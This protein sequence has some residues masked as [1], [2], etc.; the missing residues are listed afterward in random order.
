MVSKTKLFAFV[1][2]TL[3]GCGIQ[4]ALAGNTLSTPRKAPDKVETVK[5]FN[6][7]KSQ[8][9]EGIALDTQGN[10][11]VGFYPTG[12]IWKITPNGDE[13]VFATLD[14]GSSGGGMVGFEL[15]QEDNL[16]VCDATFETATHGIWKV[17]QNGM[18]TLFAKLDP[19]GFPNDLVFDKAGNL[20]VTDSYLGEIWKVS[21]S[22]EVEAWLLDRLLDPLFAYG[23][24][25]IE[26]DRG[27]L[28][29]ANTD[30]GSIVRIRMGRKG[31]PP[32]AELFVQSPVLVGADGISFDRHHNLYAT[33]DY[34][35]LLV[36]IDSQG[37]IQSMQT[38]Q[39]LAAAG[40]GLDF[41]ADTAFG[42][43]HGQRTFLFWTNGGYNFNK[44]SVQ[45]VNV[46]DPG[47][48][49]P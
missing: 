19:T 25:G 28:F 42:Q 34:Q 15:D 32:H 23:A 47:E 4:D 35:N 46:G 11:Y 9:P 37:Q 16:Y 29:V 1:L 45:K 13:S 18:P 10:I 31:G 39:T 26:F 49:L 38:I 36:A 14:V 17:D 8:L 48:P 33:V 30:Q 20:F 43:S 40:A 24:N 41:P 44:P 2:V 12:Q 6:P 21:P 3:L 22:G 27:D 7:S 5:K